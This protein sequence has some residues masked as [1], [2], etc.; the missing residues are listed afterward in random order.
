M[1]YA[2]R[3]PVMARALLLLRRGCYEES[4]PGG[5]CLMTARSAGNLVRSDRR[6]RARGDVERAAVFA[7]DPLRLDGDVRQHVVREVLRGE[8][9][10]IVERAI[11]M[12]GREFLRRDL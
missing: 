9:L 1:A 10:A 6:E 8:S 12:I 4:R 2:T 3:V 7:R 5:R 11:G